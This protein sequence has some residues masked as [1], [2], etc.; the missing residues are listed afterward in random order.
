MAVKLTSVVTI[1]AVRTSNRKIVDGVAKSLP[2][3]VT[4]FFQDLDILN[5]CLRP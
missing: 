5:A 1:I 4:A 2:S 3:G